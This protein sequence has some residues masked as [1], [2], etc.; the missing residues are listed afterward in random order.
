MEFKKGDR[1]KLININRSVTDSNHR[2][3][4]ILGEEG[5]VQEAGKEGMV[6]IFDNNHQSEEFYQWRFEKIE[7][8]EETKEEVIQHTLKQDDILT[9]KIV[10][11]DKEAAEIFFGIMIKWAEAQLK[12]KIDL[13]EDGEFG[14]S[15]LRELQLTVLNSAQG[16]LDIF[17]NNTDK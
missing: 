14:I 17:Q 6:V 15:E 4:L 12:N 3:D 8:K 16:L 7:E 9:I 11:E 13:P 2:L 10:R 5:Q 1:V